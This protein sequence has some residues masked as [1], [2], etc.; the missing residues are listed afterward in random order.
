MG[1]KNSR[2]KSQNGKEVGM[3]TE[4]EEEKEGGDMGEGK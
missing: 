2:Y 1:R 4:L 3:L